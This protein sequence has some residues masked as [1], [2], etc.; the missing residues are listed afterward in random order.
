MCAVATETFNEPSAVREQF[1][2]GAEFFFNALHLMEN[3]NFD[4]YLRHEREQ[5]THNPVALCC[6]HF[7][8]L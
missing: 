5:P 1:S 6:L 7:L 4:E 8:L 3:Y 2:L